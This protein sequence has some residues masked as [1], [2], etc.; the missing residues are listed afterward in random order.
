[1]NPDGVPVAAG[2]IAKEKALRA[3]LDHPNV[4]AF[5]RVIREGET[6]QTDEAY[7]MTFG[8]DL[9]ESLSDHPRRVVRRMLGGKSIASSA[10]GAYQFLTGTWD[11]CAAALGLPDFSPASQ[12]LAAVFLIDRRKA[13]GDVV[14]GRIDDAIRKCARE[15]ASLPGSPYGQPTKTLAQAKAVYEVNGGGYSPASQIAPAKPETEKGNAMPLPAFAIAALPALF[16]AVPRLLKSF[17]DGTS[18]AERNVAA[19]QVAIDVAKEAIGARTEQEL[20]EQ[21]KADPAAA[22]AVRAAVDENW[23]RIH[24]VGGG[25]GAARE[26]NIAQSQIEP[27][28]NLAL[29]VTAALLPLVYITVVAVLFVDG[30]SNDVRAMVVASVV[31]GLLGGI[32]GYW[33]GTSFSSA[34]KDD[35]AA[36]EEGRA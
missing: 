12:D 29:W 21:I 16:E 33:L 8:G 14:S 3:A 25:I 18:V 22:Q 31:T 15:W 26:A 34:K 6:S 11:E 30:F 20:V 23:G 4:R 24:E 2:R 36:A 28:R 1:M 27:K 35:R 5:L 9:V 32:T 13:L 10:A 7:R 17:G 19:V